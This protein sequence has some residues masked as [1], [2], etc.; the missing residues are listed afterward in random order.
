MNTNDTQ[1][2]KVSLLV[3]G[4][5]THEADVPKRIQMMDELVQ[6]A[7]AAIVRDTPFLDRVDILVWANRRDYPT[8]AD[9]GLLAPALT[10]HFKSESRVYVHEI[11]EGDLFCS[12][13]NRG[14]A[15]Q[16][17][18]GCDY[19]IIASAEANAY[20]SSD[21]PARML[22]KASQGA[23]AIGVAINEL[24]ESVREGRI[25]NTMAMW[26]IES[27]LEVGGFD[28]RAA[29]PTDDRSAYFMKGVDRHGDDRF[30]ALAGVEEVIPLARLID[31]YGRC[32]GVVESTDPALQ[33]QL[34]D[35]A[36]DPEGY[37]R[38]MAKFGTKWERQV[39]LLAM[40]GRELSYLR[41]GVMK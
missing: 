10:E 6:K 33:Y 35:L 2:P 3:R 32:I 21:V 34:P 39:A 30:Y 5:A 9:C 29:K 17:R 41:G 20:W 13:L 7:L 11:T 26:H 40:N 1:L 15:L 8:E 38:H 22:E 37:A 24:S 19:S 18:A 27:L 12:I 36:T 14:L 25:A 23:R 31:H 16:S 28:L 4:F